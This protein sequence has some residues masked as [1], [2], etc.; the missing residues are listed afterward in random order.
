MNH[1]TLFSIKQS[2]LSW[3]FLI[4]ASGIHLMM[5]GSLF[6]EPFALEHGVNLE[7]TVSHPVE[8]DKYKGFLDVWFHDTD[9]VPRGL[10]F[11]SIYQAGRNFLRGQSVFYGVREHRDGP[12]ALVVPYFSGF[13]YLPVYAYSFGVILNILPPWHS[14]WAWVIFVQI[15]LF[16]NLYLTRYIPV[17]PPIRR[18]IIAMWLAYSPYYIELHIGQQSMVTTTLIHIAV[19]AHLNKRTKLRDTSYVVSV[20]WK[21]N[22]ALFLPIW[23]KLKRWKTIAALIILTF[24]LSAPYFLLVEG[25]F[26]EFSSYFQHKFIAAGPNSLGLWAFWVQILQRFSLDHATIRHSLTIWSFIIAAT[27]SAATLLPR[28]IC[29]YKALSMW[30]CVYFLTYQYVWEHHYVMLLPVFTVGMLFK[31]LRLPTTLLWFF[32]AAPTPYIVLNDPSVPMP[33]LYWTFLEKTV[34]HGTKVIP[35]LVF[36]C[37]LVCHLINTKMNSSTNDTISHSSDQLDP[38]GWFLRRCRQI[39]KTGA[40]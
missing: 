16:F 40:L 2:R 35:V 14:Y 1:P 6:S 37:L 30:I 8:I 24:C 38:L 39:R 23:L 13:R 25:S 19:I 15:L 17:S 18:V 29:F 4:L 33:Q 3:L 28:K 21:I 7:G 26:Q 27:A 10:D 31:N 11:F 36:F 22:T 32:C 9:R 20:L 12:E 5:I 34:Y